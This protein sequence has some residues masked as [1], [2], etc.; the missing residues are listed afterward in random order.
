MRKDKDLRVQR[1]FREIQMLEYDRSFGLKRGVVGG[2][3]GIDPLPE[4]HTPGW[5]GGLQ[6]N[7]EVAEMVKGDLVVCCVL[8]GEENLFSLSYKSCSI[9]IMN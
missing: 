7:F 2:L 5:Q 4:K 6:C 1:L 9:L 8:W 3:M